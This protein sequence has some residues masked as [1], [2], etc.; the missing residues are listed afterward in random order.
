MKLHTV[1]TTFLKRNFA[2]TRSRRPAPSRTPP[3]ARPS[4]PAPSARAAPPLVA[5]RLPTASRPF[6]LPTSLSPSLHV[7]FE[8][9]QAAARWVTA[10]DRAGGPAQTHS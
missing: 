4:G 6:S 10:P 1:T 8:V 9:Q 2:H 5:A 3:T 7:P